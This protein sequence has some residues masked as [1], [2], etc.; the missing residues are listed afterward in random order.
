MFLSIVSL[1]MFSLFFRALF[2]AHISKPRKRLQNYS[3]LSLCSKF[4]SHFFY[5]SRY[6]RQQS[7]VFQQFCALKIFVQK[8]FSIK[9]MLNAGVV[10]G[11]VT[12]RLYIVSRAK[13]WSRISTACST[14]ITLLTIKLRLPA[15]SR[16]ETRRG[17]SC[18]KCNNRPNIADW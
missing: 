11:G 14:R 12:K 1:S 2:W 3:I 5:I 16:I 4:F 9:K 6:R 13:I 17:L 10:C 15:F 7:S 18:R 8:S